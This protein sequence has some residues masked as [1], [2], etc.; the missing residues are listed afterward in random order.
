M[1]SHTRAPQQKPPRARA[2]IPAGLWCAP[3]AQPLAPPRRPGRRRMQWVSTRQAS[4]HR[5]PRW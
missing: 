1:P 5:L 3:C 4:P 2:P